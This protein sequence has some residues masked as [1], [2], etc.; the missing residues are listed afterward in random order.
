MFFGIWM[1]L[2]GWH[3]AFLGIMAIPFG[4]VPFLLE[5]SVVFS[6]IRFKKINEH[7]ENQKRDIV[8]KHNE[9]KYQRMLA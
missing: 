9:M 4:I 2:D 7:I 3:W 5:F 8:S 6:V 1:I